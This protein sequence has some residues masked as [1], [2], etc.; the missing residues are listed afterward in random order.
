MLSKYEEMK[1]KNL[2]NF[3]NLTFFSTK[4]YTPYVCRT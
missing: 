1:L 3:I 2:Q 4:P